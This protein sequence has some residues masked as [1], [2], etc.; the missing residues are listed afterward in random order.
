MSKF[1]QLLKRT[2]LTHEEL[3]HV[4]N[5]VMQR[6]LREQ[7]IT[8]VRMILGIGCYP[9]TAEEIENIIGYE[10]GEVMKIF[11]KAMAKLEDS[12]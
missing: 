8:I 9:K 5:D 2:D 4:I 12:L 3:S 6:V 11:N 1:E 7:E 10:K